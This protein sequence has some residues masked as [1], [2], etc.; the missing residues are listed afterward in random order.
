MRNLQRLPGA[1]MTINHNNRKQGRFGSR[2]FSLVELLVVI[3]ILGILAASVGVYLNND[4]ARVRS[5]AF[6][7][8]SH[9]KQARF[10]AMKRSRNVYMDFDF[11]GNTVIN[12]YTIWADTNG[13]GVY[14]AGVDALISDRV[15]FEQGVEV[16]DA[17][18]ATI[19]GGPKDPNGGS[20][21]LDITDGLKTGTSSTALRFSPSGEVEAGSIYLYFPRAVAGGKQV[22]AGPLAVVV[23]SVGRVVID[24]W[25]T[26]KKWNKDN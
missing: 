13:N 25:R 10:E 23:N 15:P 20:N 19:F 17:G 7:L 26:A 24:E 14:N 6:N 3:A 9:F 1:M 11:D 16:Y 12:T 22:V 5:F 2:G 4:D 18:D 8:G 21:D